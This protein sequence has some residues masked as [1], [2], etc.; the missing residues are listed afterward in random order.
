MNE[1]LRQAEKLFGYMGEIDD[2]LVEEST[3]ARITPRIITK[4]R[5]INYRAVA[6]GVTSVVAVVYLFTKMRHGK[7]EK[8]S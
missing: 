6:T 2:F 4:R 7:R 5:E 1:K 8:V 3:M